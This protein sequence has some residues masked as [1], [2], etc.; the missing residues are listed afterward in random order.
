MKRYVFLYRIKD[1]ADRDACAYLENKLNRFVCGHYFSPLGL[2]GS[3]YRGGCWE[4]YADIE[5]ILSEDEYA[6]LRKINDELDKLGYGIK[7]G[8]ER[9]QK[10]LA[11]MEEIKPIFDK[12]NSE[13][14]D[15]FFQQ[16]VA[17]EMQ[18]VMREQDLT[19][20]EVEEAFDGYPLDYRDRSII[21]AV[22]EDVEEAGRE[23][24]YAL[25]YIEE[26]SIICE[27]YFDFERFG[28]DL[29][30]GDSLQEL[31]SGRCVSYMM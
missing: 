24:A 9:Y 2:C 14:A 5:T 8:D 23:E 7:P 19:E 25:G 12:L 22:Y 18:I 29:A 28:R 27:R 17:D 4:D 20:A 3:C 21:G 26:G 13:E 11:L 10:G 16:I 15:D 31:T 1:E 30:E 6:T